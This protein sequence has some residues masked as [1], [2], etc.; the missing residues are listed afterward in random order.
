MIEASKNFSTQN[1][2]ELPLIWEIKIE[3]KN[4][5]NFKYLI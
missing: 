5:K 4:I 3:K 1:L 2:N